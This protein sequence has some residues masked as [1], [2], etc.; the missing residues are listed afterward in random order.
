MVLYLQV[1]RR[2]HFK[3]CVVEDNERDVTCSDVS[4]HKIYVNYTIG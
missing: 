2:L 4:H 1:R 3:G